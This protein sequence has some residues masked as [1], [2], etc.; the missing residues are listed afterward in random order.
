MMFDELETLLGACPKSASYDEYAAAV[1]DDNVLRKRTLSTRQKSLR[2]LR[3]LYAL[4]VSVP[5][6]AALRILWF[7]DERSRPLLALMSAAARDPL[8]RCSV[9]LVHG[10]VPGAPLESR[11][12]ADAVQGACP[13]RFSPG[14]RDRIG[15]NLASTWTQSGHLVAASKLVPKTRARLTLTPVTATYALYLA[16]LDGNAGPMLFEGVWADLLDAN[17][18]TMQ[19]LAEDASRRGWV[20]YAAGGGMVQVGF[21]ALD[22]RIARGEG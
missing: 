22:T 17:A 9:E 8:V 16:H 7:E 19:G 10:T 21:D 6:F 14:V 13:H 12:F 3:E 20:E 2:H 1:V 4:R 18:H 15:R 11:D 5:L